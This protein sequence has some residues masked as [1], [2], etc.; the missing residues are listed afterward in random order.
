MEIYGCKRKG[1]LLV[2]APLL[3]IEHPLQRSTSYLYIEVAPFSERYFLSDVKFLTKG[4]SR[5]VIDKIVVIVKG[6]QDSKSY[7]L[8]TL[9]IIPNT[10]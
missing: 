7:E 9:Y 5:C 8:L 1:G 10:V 2:G 3:I 6:P 4:Y